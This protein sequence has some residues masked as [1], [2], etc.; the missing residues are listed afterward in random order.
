[1]GRGL[2]AE[3]TVLCWSVTMDLKRQAVFLL[4]FGLLTTAMASQATPQLTVVELYTSE[5]CSSCPP[6]DAYLGELARREGILAL[7]FHV[8]YWN[9]LGWRDA[10][11]LASLTARQQAYARRLRLNSIFTPQ[12]VVDG[13]ESF[14]GADRQRIE[15]FLAHSSPPK[16]PI[17]LSVDNGEL[18]IGVAPSETSDRNEVLLVPFRQRIIRQVAWGENRGRTLEEYNVVRELRT[19]GRTGAQAQQW[20][21]RVDAMPKDATDIAVLI[22]RPEQGEVVGVARASLTAAREAS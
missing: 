12:I 13:R 5:G 6:A 22:Q 4:G 15:S 3:G 17:A 7:S 9:D 14:V 1:M 16:Q 18:I 10:S 19:V 8:D 21:I 11:A 2:L 20:H